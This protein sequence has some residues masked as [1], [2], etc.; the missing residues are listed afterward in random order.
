MG[1]V[2]QSSGRRQAVW[3]EH[4]HI[5]SAIAAGDQKLA[6]ELIDQHSQQAGQ[7]WAARISTVL[8]RTAGDRP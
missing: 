2:L 8:K 6:V 3:D 5:A 7:T 4:E 1:A